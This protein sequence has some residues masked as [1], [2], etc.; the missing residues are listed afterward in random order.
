MEI[1][2]LE[3]SETTQGTSERPPDIRK[4]VR[5]RRKKKINV[6]G[7]SE[8]TQSSSNSR[9]TVRPRRKKSSKKFRKKPSK[10]FINK[11]EAAEIRLAFAKM[12]IG[13]S[14]LINDIDIIIKI[15]ALLTDKLLLVPSNEYEKQW[16]EWVYNAKQRHPEMED[17]DFPPLEKKFGVGE[18]LYT[19]TF[20]DLVIGNRYHYKG[21]AFPDQFAGKDPK[22][23][24]SWTRGDFTISNININK[25][26]DIF[27]ITVLLVG[28]DGIEYPDLLFMEFEFHLPGLLQRGREMHVGWIPSDHC[29]PLFPRHLELFRKIN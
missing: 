18:G 28:E 26:S 2:I 27:K 22:D 5:P 9:I 1:N 15:S 24:P 14:E 19:F 20:D 21:D 8:T 4:T 16:L 17:E 12:L 23:I 25:N 11:L 3:D 7:E 6:L 13:E 29:C 10:K